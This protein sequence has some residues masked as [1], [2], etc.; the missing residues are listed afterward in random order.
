M[1]PSV[2]T[3]FCGAVATVSAFINFQAKS[4]AGALGLAGAALLIILVPVS[5]TRWRPVELQPLRQARALGQLLL[6]S[7][8]LYW[9]HTGAMLLIAASSLLLI[10]GVGGLE[11]LVRH[12]LGASGSGLSTTDS[13]PGSLEIS[14]SGGISRTLATPIVSSAVIVYVRNLERGWDL[15]F[16]ATWSAVVR[17]IWRLLFVQLLGTVLVAVLA[18]TIIGIPYAIKKFIDWQ[19]AQQEILF[20]DRTIREALKGSTHVV[21]GHWWHTAV[22]AMTLW[23]LGQVPGLV[24]GWALLFTTLSVTSVNVIGSVIFA[25]LFPYAG[26]GRTLLYLDL[27]AREASQKVPATVAVA[28]A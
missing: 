8:R 21:R 6:A 11:T 4:T 19:F 28:P 24:V 17:R 20:E 9:R 15:G 23:V 18:L 2:A 26:I 7:V 16:V 5:L 13:S 27:L 10:A 1:E 25:L 22:V 3:A 12:A 14:T